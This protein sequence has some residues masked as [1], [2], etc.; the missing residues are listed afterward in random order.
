MRGINKAIIVGHLGND[1]DTRYTGSGTAIT[2]ISVATSESWTDKQSGEKQEKTEWH[3]I[4]FFGRLA[5]IAG[6]YLTK[7]SKVY[8]EGSLTTE[9]WTDKQGVERYTTKIKGFDLQMLGDKP[10]TQRGEH[11]PSGD[12]EPAG[13][14]EGA[15]DRARRAS[16][17]PVKGCPQPDQ[18]GFAD[19]EIPF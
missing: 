5:E 4:V 17:N 9:K 18:G 19:D 6:E 8:V 7:G 12:R 16:G 10:G 15:V 3:R 2:E 14:R 1:P 13:D 11:K